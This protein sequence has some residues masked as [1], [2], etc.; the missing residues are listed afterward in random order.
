MYDCVPAAAVDD[1]AP[2]RDDHRTM[3][4]DVPLRTA[5]SPR[6]EV[7]VAEFRA[8]GAD[9]AL[10]ET[11]ARAP[12][13]TV[14]PEHRTAH[15][16]ET[17]LSF[18]ALADS[19]ADF[20]DALDEDA[21]VADAS[22][23]EEARGR[24]RYRARLDD[25]VD[26]VVPGVVDLGVRVRDVHSEDGGWI[27]RVRVPD[28]STVPAVRER[29]A[30]R[31]VDFQLVQLYSVARVRTGAGR[32]L[33]PDQRELLLLAHRRGYFDVPRGV[34][35]TELATELGLSLP[36]VSQRLRLATSDLVART[37]LDEDDDPGR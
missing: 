32:A 35:Q 13:A 15:G 18:S 20:E 12:D 26:A 6:D 5:D 11:V 19:F 4:A 3:Y 10:A 29:W 7:L 34:A 9:L 1:P 25:R 33:P 21:T 37:L 23:V 36:A 8:E 16:D 22:H 30:E 2:A 27:L 24:R 31:G 14:R 28:R 17:Y